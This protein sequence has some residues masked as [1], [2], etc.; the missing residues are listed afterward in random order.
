MS[1]QHSTFNAYDD[2]ISRFVV[3]S[4]PYVSHCYNKSCTTL[5]C[6]VCMV[7]ELLKSAAFVYAYHRGTADQSVGCSPSGL[8]YTLSHNT[9]S[10]RATQANLLLQ[11]QLQLEKYRSWIKRK[12][13][14]YECGI[15]YH[16]QSN[17]F[18]ETDFELTACKDRKI[19]EHIWV[20]ANRA[21]SLIP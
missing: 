4:E 15:C 19:N 13:Q 1:L 12:E 14:I 11:A 16:N 21:E 10:K 5:T 2:T 20:P 6:I 8:E 17:Y 7:A 18:P 3:A 9:K